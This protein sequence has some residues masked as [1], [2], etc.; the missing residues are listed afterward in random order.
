MKCKDLRRRISRRLQRLTVAMTGEEVERL[1][2]R[3]M[4]DIDELD[5]KQRAKSV[6]TLERAQRLASERFD[7]II[8]EIEDPEALP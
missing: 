1:S 6:R 4:A 7:A 2:N 5:H 3:I 8:A